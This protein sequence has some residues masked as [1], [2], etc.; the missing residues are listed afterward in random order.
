MFP[1]RE[2]KCKVLLNN[3]EMSEKQ[4]KKMYA[5]SDVYASATRGEG[6]GL[7]I[8]KAALSGLPLIV[9]NCGGHLDFCSDYSYRVKCYTSPIHNMP[10]Y[11]YTNRDMYLY[12]VDHNSLKRTLRQAYED[13]KTTKLER[14]GALGREYA[15]K[16]L[17]TDTAEKGIRNIMRRLDE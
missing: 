6:F 11:W 3:S 7:T 5:E 2:P 17:S 14:M 1:R 4:I 8:A 9:P 13:W 16:A 12:T 15:E 10:W